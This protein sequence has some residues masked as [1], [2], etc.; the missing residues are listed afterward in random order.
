M[1]LPAPF[2]KRERWTPSTPLDAYHDPDTKGNTNEDPSDAGSQGELSP[3]Q[4]EPLSVGVNIK[5]E[6]ILPDA[7]KLKLNSTPTPPQLLTPTPTPVRTGPQLI[8]HL[9]VATEDAMRT[10]TEIP[11]NHYQY[12][13]LGRSREAQEG[14]TCDCVYEYGVD[15]PWVACGDGSDCI[16]RLTQVECLEDDCRCR[17]HCQN[18]RFQR[19]QYA[20]IEIVKTEMK[21][22]GLRAKDNIPKDAFIYEYVG[23]V[24]S[25]PSFVKR[26]REYAEEGIKHFYFMMLQKDEFIDATKRGGIGRFANHSCNP[27]CYVAKWTVG[28]HVRMGIFANRK[29]FKHEELTFNYNVDRYGHDAQPCYCGEAKCVGFIGG[30]TQTDIAAMDDLYLDALGISDEVERLGLKGSKKRKGRKLDDDWTPELKP[31]Q[32]K[33]VPKVVQAIA[34]TQSRKVMLKLLGRIKM[35]DDQA[36]FTSLMRLRGFSTMSNVMDDYSNDA[37]V[38]LLAVDC[39]AKWPMISRN[40]IDDSKISAPVEACLH[41]DNESLKEAAQKLLDAWSMLET[42]YRI[43]KR[44]KTDEWATPPSYNSVEPEPRPTKRSKYAFEP[45]RLNITPMG[46]K[47]FRPISPPPS[48]ATWATS[49]KIVPAEPPVYYVD[50]QRTKASAAAV[51]AAAIAAREAEEAKAAQK[52]VEEAKRAKRKTESKEDRE[53]RQRE[54]KDKEKRRRKEREAGR[55]ANKEKRLLKLV[56]GVVVKVMSKYRAKLDRDTFKKHAE[57]LTRIIADKEKKS[58]SYKDNRLDALSE[59]KTAKIK[60]FAKE[61]IQKVIHKLEKSGKIPKRSAASGSGEAS[62]SRLGEQDDEGAGPSMTFEDVMDL[63]DEEPEL[64]HDEDDGVGD[65]GMDDAPEPDEDETTPAEPVEPATPTPSLVDRRARGRDLG[66]EW[67][68]QKDDGV[69]KVKVVQELADPDAMIIS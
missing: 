38:L 21:G 61:Y 10:F 43:P 39:M 46:T 16:N 52:A 64:D 45:V 41:S 55:E 15:K 48:S 67:D 4:D 23:D 8:D 3:T 11:A 63:S 35:S 24:V 2:R 14:M 50:P 62:S 26:M 20:P 25:N 29:I 31:L 5:L 58:A 1:T 51:I 59:E 49:P 37:E 7:A 13:T 54:R 40:K 18:Q 47:G 42:A 44:M 66:I 65:E 36:A 30:K 9:P 22:F 60:K 6:A 17:N 12:Q 33:D 68:P 32:V 34:Q 19:R 53:K 69:E 28:H 56:G 57:E 27:N